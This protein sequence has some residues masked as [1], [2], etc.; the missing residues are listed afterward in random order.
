MIY[1]LSEIV[2]GM[3]TTASGSTQC[4]VMKLR[5]EM[6]QS[7][8]EAFDQLYASMS[9]NSFHNLLRREGYHI[10]RESLSIHR[11]GQCQCR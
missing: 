4:V 6:P 9:N 7:E 10:A 3:P 8:L 5:Q 1:L 11:K 2:A